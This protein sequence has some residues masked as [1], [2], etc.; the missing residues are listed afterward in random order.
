LAEDL[1][2]PNFKIKI[3]DNS[4]IEIVPFAVSQTQIVN[5][6]EE[7]YLLIKSHKIGM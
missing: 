5:Y 1:E 4:N 6:N 2:K 3:K 7:L